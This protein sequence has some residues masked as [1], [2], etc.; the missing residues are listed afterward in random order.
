MVQLDQSLPGF[1]VMPGSFQPFARSDVADGRGRVRG[2]HLEGA[3]VG[4]VE[5]PLAIPPGHQHG[6]DF[7]DDARRDGK[8]GPRVGAAVDPYV[9]PDDADPLAG[10]VGA[11]G[12]F[13]RLVCLGELRVRAV[14][15]V[16]ITV[17]DLN[18]GRRGEIEEE[19]H[20]LQRE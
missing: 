4:I 8:C 7:V 5:R 3:N 2:Q 12:E 20:R 15:D 19:T 14:D 10:L 18:E 6:S 9:V 11:L 13:A 17:P 1:E 16:E